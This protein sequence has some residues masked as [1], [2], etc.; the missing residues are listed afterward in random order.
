[1]WTKSP[2]GGRQLQRK[3]GRMK[4]LDAKLKQ[5]L[6]ETTRANKAAERDSLKNEINTLVATREHYTRQIRQL[7]K[8][9]KDLNSRLDELTKSR[10]NGEESLYTAVDKIF[11]SIG[12]NRAHYF[13]RAF[14][15]VHIKKIM[16]KSDYL[17]G[18]GGVIQQKLL[19]HTS[20]SDKAVLVNKVCDDVGLAFK[21]WDGAFSAIHSPN[22]TVEHCTETQEQIDKAMAHTRTMGF[23]VTPKMHGMESHVVRQMR[24]IPGGIGML[25]EHWIEHYHQTGYQFDLAY[26]RVGSL[27]GQAAI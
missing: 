24:T 13:G 27:V 25:M 3:H 26:C 23:S 9:V 1:V 10:R 2:D 22:P 8:N 4:R 14:E 19:E 15:G 5:Y 7:D 12:A 21:L 16:A 11:Q 6:D 18:V 20:N 17:F